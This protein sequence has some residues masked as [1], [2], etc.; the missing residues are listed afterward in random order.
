[1]YFVFLTHDWTDSVA[2]LDAGIIGLGLAYTIALAGILQYCVR[3]SAEV[4][5]IVSIVLLVNIIM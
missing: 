3:Q 1:M 4:E 2:G 5:N